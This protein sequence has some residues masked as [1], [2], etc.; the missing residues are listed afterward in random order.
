MA[1]FNNFPYVNMQELNLDYLIRKMKELQ[2]EWQKMAGDVSA[3][4]HLANEVGVTV[5][6]DLKEGLNFDFALPPTL[7]ATSSRAGIVQPDNK[8]IK[9]SGGVISSQIGGIVGT[10]TAPGSNVLRVDT[11]TK[12][13]IDARLDSFGDGGGAYSLTQG[14]IKV[15]EEGHYL[16]EGSTWCEASD[17]TQSGTIQLRIMAGG[18]YATAAPYGWGLSNYIV[19]APVNTVMRVLHLPADTV[20]FLDAA[21]TG[22]GG[23]YKYANNETQLTVVKLA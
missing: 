4:A 20:I 18:N 16:I 9:V 22:S 17:P 10:I 23:V 21:M 7:P 13:P 2:A 8:T 14:G 5:D 6:G 1:I 15:N 12:L 3:T 19:S 11:F